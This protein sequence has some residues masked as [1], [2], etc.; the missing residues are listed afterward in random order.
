MSVR[1]MIADDEP[2]ARERIRTLLAARSELV[3]VAE[4]GDG[5][6][7][8][9]MIGAHAPDLLFLDVQMPGLGGFELLGALDEHEL[10]TV[11]FV[12]AFD[13]YALRAFDVNA[14]D[15]L[16][17]P[18]DR[19]RF[20]KA[21][22]RAMAHVA[23]R[24]TDGL[25]ADQQL[26]ALVAELRA[27]R[28]YSARFVV[29]S[30]EGV[31]FVRP[32]E[33]D[34]IDAAG[35]YVRLHAGGATHLMRETMKKLEARLDPDL[36]VRVHRSAIINIERVRK[37]EPYVHGEYIV[38]MKDGTTLTSSRTHSARLRALLR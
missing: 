26:L 5:V 12:T 32:E 13:E 25:G 16:L 35:N 22:A 1:V 17:K 18:F 4:C 14:V 21:L 27:E 31:A 30:A 37:V 6:E 20:D 33:I 15:Y 29:R 11:V 24:R 7:A 36:F 34:W 2:L 10:P 3:V 28:R 8:L 23:R 38:T 19:A 9:E